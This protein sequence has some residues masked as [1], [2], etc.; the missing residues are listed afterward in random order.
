MVTAGRTS[1]I[2]PR[3]R[4]A[5]RRGGLTT[6]ITAVLA[7]LA[8][9]LGSGSASA[10]SLCDIGGPATQAI[11]GTAGKAAGNLVGKAVGGSFDKIV[12]SLLDGY[13]TVLT[14]ALAW[15]IKL[16]TPNLDPSSS[17]MRDIHSHTVQLQIIGLTFSM[18][19]FALRMIANHKQSVADDAE[20]GFKLILRAGLAV[21]AIPMALTLGGRLC[22]GFSNW[23][24]GEAINAGGNNGDIV[25]NFLKLDALTNSPLGSAAIGLFALVGFLGAVF[26]LI[27]LVV[28]EAMLLLVISGLPIAAAFSGTGP[29]SQSYQRLITWSVAFLLFKPVGALTYFIAFKAAG[30]QKD[31]QMVVL[32]MVLMGLCAFVLPSLMRLI[33]PA[34]SSMGSGGSGLAAAGAAIGAAVA[35]GKVAGMAATGGASGGAGG[36]AGGGMSSIASRSGGDSGGSISS[37]SDSGSSSSPPPPSPPTG[38]SGGPQAAM[39]GGDPG[40]GSTS[41]SSG[42]AKG[43][44]TE[45]LGDAMSSGSGTAGAVSGVADQLDREADAPDTAP[46]MQS[47]WNEHA[48]SR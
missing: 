46:P 43:G 3:L 39:S 5:A 40:S 19:F 32:G 2:H 42:A 28:R 38:G 9:V 16:P 47:G 4:L 30:N 44:P 29:G 31:A 34:V 1:R 12:D 10:F 48:M 45:G 36:G 24:I 17:L 20:E 41:S 33:A 14:W 37:S 15:W 11:C 27:L 23:L 21:A 25:K 18:T 35:V 6:A 22:D 8:T 7:A 13:Q 26:Q